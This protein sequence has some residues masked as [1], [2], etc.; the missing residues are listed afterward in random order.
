M[1]SREDGANINEILLRRDRLANLNASTD[2]NNDEKASIL[3]RE[4]QDF[5]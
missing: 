1:I 4:L 2:R 5:M 3:F